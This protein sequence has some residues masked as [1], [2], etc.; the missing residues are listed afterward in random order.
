MEGGEDNGE[1]HRENET[2]LGSTAAAVALA[3]SNS[4]PPAPEA[5]QGETQDHV[6][7]SES[8]EEGGYG[9]EENEEQQEEELE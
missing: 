7:S 1:P 5:L 4:G 6:A 8:E 3:G 2:G 9:D